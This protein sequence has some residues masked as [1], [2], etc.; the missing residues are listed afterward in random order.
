MGTTWTALDNVLVKPRDFKIANLQGEI[1]RLKETIQEAKT[2]IT[3]LKE[4]DQKKGAEI[5][6][7][8]QERKRLKRE[9][10][11]LRSS[12]LGTPELPA[13]LQ[14]T[15]P[16]KI[17]ELAQS[18]KE[19]FER[20]KYFRYADSDL[21]IH[22]KRLETD[23]VILRREYFSADKG[24]EGTFGHGWHYSFESRIGIDEST[25]SRIVY[26]SGSGELIEFEPKQPQEYLKLLKTYMPEASLNTPLTK[27]FEYEK[28]NHV[29]F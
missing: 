18:P 7:L 26:Y 20:A 12:L 24:G 27:L 21:P 11:E 5:S 28:K 23:S 3:R 9:Q 16:P 17:F 14:V 13:L 8:I 1:N 4:T 19:W 29:S 15:S 22:M 10:K 25:V 2:D 6:K